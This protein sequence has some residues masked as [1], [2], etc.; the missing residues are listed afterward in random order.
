MA[1]SRKQDDT[2]SVV[3]PPADSADEATDTTP[4]EFHE[5]PA[6][7][8]EAGPVAPEGSVEVFPNTY[9]TDS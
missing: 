8:T 6:P 4:Q 3:P 5:Q 7:A 9:R 2:D 1:K